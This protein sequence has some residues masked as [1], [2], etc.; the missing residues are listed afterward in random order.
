MRRVI[1]HPW[2]VVSVGV[3]VHNRE[4]VADN[5]ALPYALLRFPRQSAMLSNMY[6]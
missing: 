6:L 2:V 4:R 5:L 3:Q 1:D